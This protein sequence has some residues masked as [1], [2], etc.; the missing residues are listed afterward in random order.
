MPVEGRIYEAHELESTTKADV[1][2]KLD[3]WIRDARD[4]RLKRLTN[5]GF[6]RSDGA[7]E[8]LQTLRQE[9]F[10]ERLA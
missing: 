3:T 9:L 6:W 8:A 5:M 4:R 10:G 7:L 2:D 1:L